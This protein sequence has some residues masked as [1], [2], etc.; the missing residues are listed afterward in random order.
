MNMVILKNLIKFL[1]CLL[2]VFL[3]LAALGFSLKYHE[4]IRKKQGYCTWKEE[5]K[6]LI[7]SRDQRLDV[8]INAYLK[9][10]IS[11]D[12]REIELIG[13]NEK[14]DPAYREF[15]K[16]H[17]SLIRYSNREEFLKD[18]P[19]CC[20]VVGVDI[21]APSGDFWDWASNPGTIVFE[22]KHKIRYTDQNGNLKQI[23]SYHTY[24]AIDNCGGVEPIFPF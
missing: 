16:S 13:N 6:G 9:D 24:F 12:Y 20:A 5:K 23:P 11:I 21:P 3:V 2:A 4:N 10:Q 18:N 14:R 1:A 19:Q 22:V 7:I 8:A 17:F 15:I